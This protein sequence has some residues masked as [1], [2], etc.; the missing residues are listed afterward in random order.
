[1]SPTGP[2]FHAGAS[3]ELTKIRR[4]P[5]LKK[6]S[7]PSGGRLSF[8]RTNCKPLVSRFLDSGLGGTRTH[9][10]RLKRALLSCVNAAKGDKRRQNRILVRQDPMSCA[11][12]SDEEKDF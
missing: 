1:V 9:N 8:W 6:Q 10:Q 12:F 4:E 7:D 2:A 5:A 11:I 3:G